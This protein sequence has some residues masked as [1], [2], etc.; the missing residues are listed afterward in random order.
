MYLK[1]FRFYTRS[2]DSAEVTSTR[3]NNGDYSDMIYTTNLNEWTNYL[4]QDFKSTQSL[5]YDAKSRQMQQVTNKFYHAICPAFTY[6]KDG[7]C[8]KEPVNKMRVSVFPLYSKE[9]K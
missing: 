2:L 3:Y 4:V 7:Y 1:G 5:A 8:Y 6:Y 9:E